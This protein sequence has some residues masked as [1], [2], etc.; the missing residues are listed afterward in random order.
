MGRPVPAPFLAQVVLPVLQRPIPVEKVASATNT[1]AA[2]GGLVKGI[3]QEG[4][5]GGDDIE[6]NANN[7]N[8]NSKLGQKSYRRKQLKKII[9][10]AAGTN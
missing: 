1:T 7:A 8:N 9:E 5:S 6:R 10:L 4:G 2:G 3:V